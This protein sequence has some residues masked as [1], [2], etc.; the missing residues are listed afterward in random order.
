MEK[1]HLSELIYGSVSH[2]ITGKWKWNWKFELQYFLFV[3]NNC[4]FY[5]EK[6]VIESTVNWCSWTSDTSW[7][8]LNQERLNRKFIEPVDRTMCLNVFP[9][10]SKSKDCL[11]LTVT[12]F[13][14]SLLNILKFIIN[15]L[16]WVETKH[17]FLLSI[18]SYPSTHLGD[19]GWIQKHILGT[20]STN[21]EQKSQ[22]K[23]NKM[24][25][26]GHGSFVDSYFHYYG[27]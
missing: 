8:E 27:N 24:R 15:P 2:Q 21:F 18:C 17:C 5:M 19:I 6:T 25:F 4:K 1:S 14:S 16:I 22:A 13:S 26:T 9:K 3:G 23:S 12:L 20:Q 11:L 10:T 7:N